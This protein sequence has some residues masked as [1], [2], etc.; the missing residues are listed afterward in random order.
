VAGGALLIPALLAATTRVTPARIHGL[1]VAVAVVLL[2]AYGAGLFFSL[3]THAHL[4]TEE[5][6]EALHGTPRWSVRR[7]QLQVDQN[8]FEIEALLRRALPKASHP[9]NQMARAGKIIVHDLLA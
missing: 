1:S 3:R 2:L 8:D 9:S 4:Y 5:Q 6:E 7:A